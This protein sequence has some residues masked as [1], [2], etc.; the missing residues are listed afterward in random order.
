MAGI[1]HQD[2]R[3]T[4]ARR[5]ATWRRRLERRRAVQDLELTIPGAHRP[6]RLAAPASLDAVL[7]ETPAEGHLP[8]WAT[9]WASGLAQ[10][11]L[12][13]ARRDAVSGRRIL[14]LGC[15][16]GVTAAAAL[17]V[18]GPTGRF[19]AVDCF[20]ETLA[21]CRYNALRNAGRAPQTMLVDWRTT[22]GMDVL[23]RAAPFELVL[24]AD[25]LY[26]LE[27]VAPLLYL[28]P[29]LLAPGGAFWLAEPGRSTS[30]RFVELAGSHGWRPAET[31]DLERAWPA[32]A[33]QARVRIHLFSAH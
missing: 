24:A 17:S 23:L 19:L 5:L 4:T 21:Y 2:V 26:E 8:Y 31:I 6:Y 29:R 20:A 28:T 11:E 10:A 18:L 3:G 9:P 13:L 14:E 16:L 1:V 7:D 22:A 27:D 12:V 15:G 33:G 25:V 30:A 32:G